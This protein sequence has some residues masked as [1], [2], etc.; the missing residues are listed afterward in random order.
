MRWIRYTF[1]NMKTKELVVGAPAPDAILTDD[2]GNSVRLSDLWKTGALV[3]VFYPG[4]QSPGCTIQ[5]CAIRDD[6][7]RFQEAGITVVGINHGSAES[8]TRFREQHAFPFSLLVDSQKHTSRTFGATRSIF[9]FEIIRRMV[10]G[11]DRNGT[12]RYIRN[13][14]PRHADIL[15]ALKP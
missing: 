11:I 4:D 13:G 3:V 6:W 14:M 15:K 9:G 8:H 10:V 5:L 1:P 7:T 2:H 12:V